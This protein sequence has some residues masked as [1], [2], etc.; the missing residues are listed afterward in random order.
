MCL[1]KAGPGEKLKEG[2]DLGEWLIRGATN[3]SATGVTE[4]GNTWSPAGPC[5]SAST[6]AA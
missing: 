6:T 4:D 2:L 3:E 1:G 5:L